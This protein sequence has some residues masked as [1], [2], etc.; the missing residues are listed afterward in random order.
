MEQLL[1]GLQHREEAWIQSATHWVRRNAGTVFCAA[2]LSL[3]RD[4]YPAPVDVPIRVLLP[5]HIID[6]ASDLYGPVGVIRRDLLECLRPHLRG[7]VIGRCL[8]GEGRV[9]DSHMTLY[10]RSCITPRYGAEGKCFR[11]ETCG[12]IW[13]K[14]DAERHSFMSYELGGGPV[15]QTHVCSTY[16]LPSVV[17]GLNLRSFPGLKCVPFPVH[18][19][20]EDGYR[21]PSDPSWV[22]GRPPEPYSSPHL[23]RRLGD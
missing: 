6:A 5:G 18:D 21:L 4:R 15:Y 10:S 16:V 11:C 12:T 22:R 17:E 14:G 19:R 3:R 1:Y 7:F 9:I 2:C 13:S 20:P 23:N 8:D